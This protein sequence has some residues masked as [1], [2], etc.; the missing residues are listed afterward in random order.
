MFVPTEIPTL[1][2]V[3]CREDNWCPFSTVNLKLIDAYGV[4]VI[5]QPSLE[6]GNVIRVGQGDIADRIA[7]HRD[8][9]EIIAYEPG[10]RVTWA[11]VDWPFVDGVERYLGN[12]LRPAVGTHFPE[13]DPIPV[14]LPGR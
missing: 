8:D 7:M 14:N 2:W 12:T 9:P 13:E 10:L 6:G 1:Q 4:Y 11:A 3:K 5:W